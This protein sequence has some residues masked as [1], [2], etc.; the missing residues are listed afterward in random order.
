MEME[1]DKAKGLK[2]WE[3]VLKKAESK[4]ET[5]NHLFGEQYGY[6]RMIKTAANHISELNKIKK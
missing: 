6:E 4:D 3:M 5:V 2:H 1:I